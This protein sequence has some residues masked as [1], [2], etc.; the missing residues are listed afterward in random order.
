MSLFC[1]QIDEGDVEV[2][3]SLLRLPQPLAKQTL[4]R[5][6]L[7]LCGHQQT[8]QAALQLLVSLLRAPAVS[9]AGSPSMGGGAHLHHWHEPLK[10]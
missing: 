9:E 6:F 4:Q 8:R 3:V 5:V 10:P 2:L 7:N 1:A